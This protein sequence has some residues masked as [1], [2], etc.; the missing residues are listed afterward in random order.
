MRSLRVFRPS[1]LL[2]EPKSDLFSLLVVLMVKLKMRSALHSITAE[3]AP[4]VVILV[5]AFHGLALERLIR[6]S[7]I[8]QFAGIA[9]TDFW[10]KIK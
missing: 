7:L 2:D 3:S 10:K 1:R 9:K 6:L 5:M 4:F 8:T